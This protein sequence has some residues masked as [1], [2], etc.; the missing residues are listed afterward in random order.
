MKMPAE[1]RLQQAQLLLRGTD[2]RRSLA[3][4]D[5]HGSVADPLLDTMNFLNEVTA[6]YPQAVSFAPGRPYE[7]LFDPACIAEYLDAYTSYLRDRGQTSDQVRAALFQYGR[8][9]GL[10]HDLIAE[11]VA[12]DEGIQVPPESVV[13]TVGAQE[14]MFL[15]LRVLF[16]GP[17]DVLLVSSPCY[18]GITGAARLL[19]IEVI[20]VPEGD[21][22]P[23]PDA[24]RQAARMAAAAGKRPRALYVVPDFANPSGASM[25]VPARAAL[26]DVAAAG[27][28]LVIE[29]NPYGF[30]AREIAARP[31][32]KSMDTAGTV[33]YLGSFAKTCF[34]GARLG[35]LLADQDVLA[36]DG[37]RSLLA[38]EIAKVKSMVTVNTPSLSQAVIGGM[39]VRCG[40]RLRE[41]NTA[42]AA[43]YRTN[44]LTLLAELER[45]FPA[46]LRSE[47]AISWNYPDGGFF[48]VLTVPFAV[49]EAALE[50]SAREYGVLW[51]PMD[52]FFVGGGGQHQLR[53]SSSYL[54]PDKVREGVARLAAFI[55]AEASLMAG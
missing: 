46:G 3:L 15:L 43:F 10:I 51:T 42:N 36:R 13:V 27:N 52:A 40:C 31:T 18:I 12:N 29:D 53:I 11:T 21:A 47:L 44:L 23:D 32:L 6:R 39:L 8:T 26:L 54:A 41:V 20:P 35:Y 28:M 24:A 49:N 17:R 19:D 14:A 48:T 38:D 1:A 2:A 4:A 34:P 5:L 45:H 9:K 7:G 55:R 33:V 16:T 37:R 30:F 22:G 50:R 25:T